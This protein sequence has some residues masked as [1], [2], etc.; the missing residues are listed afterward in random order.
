LNTEIAHL[1]KL[2]TKYHYRVL[3]DLESEA[4]TTTQEG[5]LSMR[6]VLHCDHTNL[7]SITSCDRNTVIGCLCL[8]LDQPSSMTPALFT[9]LVKNVRSSD[10]VSTVRGT[11]TF[12]PTYRTSSGQLQR[13]AEVRVLPNSMRDALQ[14]LNGFAQRLDHLGKHFQ[15][16][17]GLPPTMEASTPPPR[18]PSPRDPGNMRSS[19]PE[20]SSPPPVPAPTARSTISPPVPE[21]IVIPSPPAPSAYPGT[22]EEINHELLAELEAPLPDHNPTPTTTPSGVPDEQPLWLSAINHQE[23]II[24]AL[25]VILAMI[26]VIITMVLLITLR[27]RLGVDRLYRLLDPAP[28]DGHAP[29]TRRPVLQLLEEVGGD[30]HRLEQALGQGEFDKKLEVLETLL[31]NAATVQKNQHT[32]LHQLAQSTELL[33]ALEQRLKE[34]PGRTGEVLETLDRQLEALRQR[35]GETFRELEQ[36]MVVRLTT[37]LRSIPEGAKAETRLALTSYGEELN[38]INRTLNNLIEQLTPRIE[39]KFTHL[40]E[41][42]STSLTPPGKDSD[43]QTP[44]I[45][46]TLQELQTRT[47]EDKVALLAVIDRLERLDQALHPFQEQLDTLG[48]TAMTTLSTVRLLLEQKVAQVQP[49]GE[50]RRLE[51]VIDSLSEA[52][53]KLS[54]LRSPTVTAPASSEPNKLP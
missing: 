32:Y 14:A 31:A 3:F 7:Q 15:L 17:A 19:S 37:I 21:S 26:I 20:E 45:L 11:T 27:L 53:G 5:F 6:D 8:I 23:V 35:H 25:I 34:H 36:D 43:N 44:M 9:Q 13:V 46:A 22:N 38:G 49:S 51:L 54:R 42:I 50:D 10:F 4:G 28:L 47:S 39:G 18:S 41:K 12:H 29:R 24:P 48:Q 16:T 52:L 2:Y 30:L 40:I 1:T 33:G